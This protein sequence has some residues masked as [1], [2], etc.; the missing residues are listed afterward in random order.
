MSGGAFKILFGAALACAGILLVLFNRTLARRAVDLQRRRLERPSAVVIARII[1]AVFGLA[2]LLLGV[3]AML[4][5][6]T[7]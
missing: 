7:E 5:L 3:L 2:C 4:G 6:M 1:Y